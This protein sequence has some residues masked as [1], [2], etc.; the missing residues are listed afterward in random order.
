MAL[1]DV[2]LAP[3]VEL[4]AVHPVVLE[5]VHRLERWVEREQLAVPQPAGPLDGHRADEP[6]RLDPPTAA[7]RLGAR[8]DDLP[9][10]R[11]EPIDGGA[12]D[13]L[14]ALLLEERDPR[15]DPRLV[16]RRVEDAVQGAVVAA[17]HR[18][19]DE[20][21]GHVA[22]RAGTRH[23]LLGGDQVA[24][25]AGRK[26][27]LVLRR[28]RVGLEVVPPADL[29]P[30]AVAA[31]VAAREEDREA[32][33]EELDLVGRDAVPGQRLLEV[34][35][36]A[37]GRRRLLRIRADAEQQRVGPAAVAEELAA[38]GVLEVVVDAVRVPGARGC[39]ASCRGCGGRS[40]GRSG[41]R[42]R[43][44]APCARR[45]PSWA[46]PCCAPCRRARGARRR[47]PRSRAR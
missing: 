23:R 36:H 35:L 7:A 2:D 24:R 15:V 3:Q 17:A 30:L 46:R 43:P 40:R 47:S 20:R 19:V 31:L 42:A 8:R 37:V 21:L 39:A 34:A 44:A 41:T 12:D 22:D 5:V 33:G 25:E 16:G 1:G 13:E 38:L 18:V 28:L 27:L 45:P 29:L 32:L 26:H 14:H 4:D 6:V 9:A 10:P 11:L